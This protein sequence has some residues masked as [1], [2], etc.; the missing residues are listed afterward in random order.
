MN[1]NCQGSRSRVCFPTFFA[2]VASLMFSEAAIA[3]EESALR[4]VAGIAGFS[5]LSSSGR[6]ETV[7]IAAADAAETTGRERLEWAKVMMADLG[8]IRKSPIGVDVSTIDDILSFRSWCVE[9]PGYGN[10]L[11]ATAA[12]EAAVGLLFRGLASG[13]LPAD[14][15]ERLW[16]Q[17]LSANPSAD[18]WMATLAREGHPFV[19]GIVIKPDIPEYLR[20]AAICNRLWDNSD[21][22]KATRKNLELRLQDDPG[23]WGGDPE[24]VTAAEL[25]L[26]LANLSR[27]FVALETCLAI[28]SGL[29]HIPA[30]R[31]EFEAAA[32]KHAWNILSKRERLG[33]R[34]TGL[35][36]WKIWSEALAEAKK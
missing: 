5:L 12:E 24:T 16:V 14:D 25:V 17:G 29:G 20:L 4:E 19:K 34:M 1:A 23:W 32:D 26:R 7:S 22:W 21:E 31:G 36:V 8:R 30:E 33:G 9:A 15:I 2:A 3:R 35:E 27:Q 10:L 28:Q 18:Y 11:L 6:V 13:T